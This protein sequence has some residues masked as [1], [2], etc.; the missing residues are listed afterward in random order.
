MNIGQ[1]PTEYYITRFYYKLYTH[2]T[3]QRES[4]S[5]L[6]FHILS[7]IEWLAGG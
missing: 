6:E 4:G 7:N 1:V 2:N 3:T 5:F